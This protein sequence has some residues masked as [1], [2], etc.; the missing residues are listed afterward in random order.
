MWVEFGAAPLNSDRLR[1]EIKEKLDRLQ[2]DYVSMESFYNFHPVEVSA[3]N[4]YERG[5]V[6]DSYHKHVRQ[7]GEDVVSM[8]TDHNKKGANELGLRHISMS[9]QAENSDSWIQRIHRRDPDIVAGEFW[10]TTSFNSR[11]WGGSTFDVDWHLGPFDHDA[12]CH[13]GDISWDV[14]PNK[15]GAGGGVDSGMKLDVGILV[16]DNRGNTTGRRFSRNCARY[17]NRKFMRRLRRW[18]TRAN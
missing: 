12:G 11:N 7:G 15:G 17:T 16:S 13:T 3:A 10:L 18:L 1:D 9:G 5:Q 14:C 8:L 2:P 4:L 6:I